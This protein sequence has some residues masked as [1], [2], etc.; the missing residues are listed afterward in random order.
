MN[1]GL[2]YWVSLIQSLLQSMIKMSAMAVVI[3]GFN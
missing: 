1:L 3:S 2:A